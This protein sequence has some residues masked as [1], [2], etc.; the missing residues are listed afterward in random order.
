MH[1][2]IHDY[3]TNGL[4]F[5]NEQDADKGP[6]DASDLS[7]T[8]AER[9]KHTVKRAEYSRKVLE[10]SNI[11][12]STDDF[13][14]TKDPAEVERLKNFQN[15]HKYSNLSVFSDRLPNGY[16]LDAALLGE[17]P[18]ASTRLSAED[19]ARQRERKKI[20]VKS[21]MTNALSLKLKHIREKIRMERSSITVDTN[22]QYESASAALKLAA[23]RAEKATPEELRD[24]LERFGTPSEKLFVKGDPKEELLPEKDRIKLQDKRLTSLS[25]E[26]VG[27]QL[28]QEDAQ[29]LAMA[30]KEE[31]LRR[32]ATGRQHMTKEEELLALI[33]SMGNRPYVSI[34][35]GDLEQEE[36][37]VE[38]LA[39]C[40][41]S[42]ELAEPDTDENGNPILTIKMLL[43]NLVP[44][45][46]FGFKGSTLQNL[47]ELQRD[48]RRI[49]AIELARYDMGTDEFNPESEHFSRK[50]MF[51]TNG[52]SRAVNRTAHHLD[53]DIL[54]YLEMEDQ[55]RHPVDIDA[56]NWSEELP[57]KL[58]AKYANLEVDGEGQHL[59]SDLTP[60]DIMP[61]PWR[62]YVN[63]FIF[64]GSTGILEAAFF[65]EPVLQA[66]QAIS[67]NSKPAKQVASEE[68]QSAEALLSSYAV[69][70]AS[71][72][73][74]EVLTLDDLLD[75]PEV[76]QAKA[77]ERAAAAAAAAQ[78]EQKQV[79]A[80]STAGA[81][82][83]EVEDEELLKVEEEL[84]DDEA[85]SKP[86][87]SIVGSQQPK[88]AEA[89][90]TIV[91][92]GVKYE[93]PE[94]LLRTTLDRPILKYVGKRN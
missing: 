6:S 51:D 69:E 7:A 42:D 85:V 91:V 63:H 77:K 53:S 25:L 92:D 23:M 67:G 45:E 58:G 60:E 83:L 70:G 64:S 36:T 66:R 39:K 75:D 59:P 93:I 65:D 49:V 5:S 80:D 55:N 44:L 62:P 89:E 94:G 73:E 76:A 28:Q 57:R 17:K 46:Q 18:P 13:L 54:E 15:L 31:Q 2:Q 9:L 3:I 90:N 14:G 34:V 8:N 56:A 24:L 81:E 84:S 41:I 10:A 79:D 50:I 74:D 78:A 1:Y 22:P 52:Y 40:K 47:K 87:S 88:K 29:V 38:D 20:P 43:T 4:I 27:R 71:Q 32:A 68:S 72:V 11:I 86:L 61:E 30:Q 21:L 48:L 37:Q 35:E 12:Q 33:D 19:R 26:L 82:K 16:D